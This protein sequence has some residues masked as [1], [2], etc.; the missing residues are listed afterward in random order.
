MLPALWDGK[1][2]SNFVFQLAGRDEL[3]LWPAGAPAAPTS[4][5]P[6][7]GIAPGTNTTV[8]TNATATTT[9]YRVHATGSSSGGVTNVVNASTNP[10]GGVVGWLG[11]TN[12]G[13]V[14]V[15][16]LSVSGALVATD[17]GTNVDLS[18]SG[19]VGEANFN[20]DVFTNSVVLGWVYDKIGVTNRLRTFRVGFGLSGTNESTNLVAAVDASVIAGQTDL[21]AASNVLRGDIANLQGATNGLHGRVG[22]LEGA[23][24]GLRTDVLNL[25]GGTNGLATRVANLEGGTNG[26]RTDVLNLQGATNGLRTD[27]LNLQGATN[28]LR[29]DVLNLQAITNRNANQFGASATLTVKD[30]AKFTNVVLEATSTAYQMGVSN[31]V[32]TNAAVRAGAS[33]SN[34]WIGG[35]IYVD[36]ASRT[37]HST[38]NSYTN[39]ATF[40]L[41]AH[42]LTNSGDTVEATWTGVYLSGTN[43]FVMGFGSIT[44]VVDVSGVTNGAAVPAGWRASLQ[45]TRTANTAQRVAAWIQFNLGSGITYAYTNRLI[46]IAE[47]NGIDNLIRLQG[48]AIRA[49]GITNNFLAV[50]FRPGPR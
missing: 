26:L 15:K 36:L 48:S 41:P 8:S 4:V 3:L 9:T 7:V 31:L 20:A 11:P 39:L 28:G 14:R 10:P 34:A 18:T 42:A 12:N 24:N 30:G 29:T 50:E 47:T 33:A 16:T 17:Q 32:A 6:V 35:V 40:T 37:N 2:F 38:V 23:T 44:N 5:A 27:A 45:I 46:D 1:V 19:G 13:D 21:N 49:G 25:Q 22:N 43:R